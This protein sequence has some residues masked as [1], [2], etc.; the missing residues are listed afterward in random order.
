MLS[1]RTKQ[2][3]RRLGVFVIAMF[4]VLFILQAV[5]AG[6]LTPS[7]SPAGTFHTLG[8]IFNPLASTSYD[9]STITSS[10]YGNALQITKCIITKLH[11]RGC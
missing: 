11:G 7:T 2:R 9:S 6:S 8:E 10:S 4:A 5:Q 3:F 1:D